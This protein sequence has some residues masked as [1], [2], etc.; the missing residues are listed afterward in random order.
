MLFP[1]QGTCVAQWRY[2]Q[3]SDSLQHGK[4]YQHPAIG[5]S[6]IQ[7]KKFVYVL[8]PD[9]TLKYTEI[10]I[11]NLDNGKEYLV[12]SG[13][14]AGDKIVIEGVQ[15]LKDGQKIQPITPAQK[16]ANY[17]QHLKDQH[18]GNLATAFN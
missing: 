8:Q 12:T 7:D 4:R 6:G 2:C 3:R 17:Q 15:N 11:F 14:N 18:D 10:G 13:L 5:N 16:E 9:N 1:Q